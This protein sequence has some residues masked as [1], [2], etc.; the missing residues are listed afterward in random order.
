MCVVLMTLMLCGCKTSESSQKAEESH[1]TQIESAA[2]LT[3]VVA[4][5]DQGHFT[6][7]YQG[8][9]RKFLLYLPQGSSEGIP[10]IVMLHG[11]ADDA[12]AFAQ[13]TAMHETARE[14]GYAV[15]YPQGIQDPGDKTSGAGWNSGLKST[16]NDDTGF[17]VALVRYLQ[18]NDGVDNKAVFAAGFSNG[19]F[20][21]YRL[22]CEAS[23]TFRAIASVA[24]FM[25][26]GAWAEREET[27]SIGI[28]Q[29]N[30][31]KDDVVPMEAS[32]YTNTNA[33]VPRIEE[34]IRYWKDANGLHDYLEKKLSNQAT[35][36][37]YSDPAVSNLVW[38]I[39]IQDGR[40][41]WPQEQFSGID[42]NN[43]ILEFF[44]HHRD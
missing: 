31:T 9:T 20:M 40:H 43:M 18:E 29:I 13:K 5:D 32:K 11:Y 6:C 4:V 1:V 41:S 37:C 35:A 12:D 24:G 34:A 22:A 16:G 8:Q 2:E 39:V 30:G 44:E 28:L 14:Y 19:A 21:T 27:A 38:H 3:D 7:D 15:V 42:T 33:K 26:E 25:T 17:L 23:D 36:Y 10:L